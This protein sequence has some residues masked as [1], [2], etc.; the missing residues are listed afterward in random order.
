M[1]LANHRTLQDFFAGLSLEVDS[2]F[3]VIRV[4]ALLWLMLGVSLSRVV[5]K[6]CS[7]KRSTHARV[8]GGS[9]FW[10]EQR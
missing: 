7:V 1:G 5:R 6:G 2:R 3:A 9:C 4:A 10:G 8:E